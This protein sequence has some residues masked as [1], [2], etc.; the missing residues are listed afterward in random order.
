ME[1]VPGIYLVKLPVPSILNH[2][3][4]YLIRGKNGW[5][6]IDTGMNYPASTEIWE[7]TFKHMGL[8]FN[9]IEGIYLTHLHPDQYGASGW[10]QALTGAPVYLSRTE[11]INVDQILKKGRTTV[12][13]VGELLKENGMPPGLIS[14]VLESIEKMWK[15]IL[16]H[17]SI[18]ELQEKEK[19]D[20]GG[21]VFEVIPTPGHTDGHISFFCRREGML[22]SGDNLLPQEYFNV[23]LWPT[24]HPNPLELYMDTLDMIGKLPVK[25]ALPSHGPMLGN[26]AQRASELLQHHRQRL[27]RIEELAGNGANA[28]QICLSLFGNGL[29]VHQIRLALM[30]TLAHLACLESR[31]KVA[32]RQEGGIV[33]YR[34]VA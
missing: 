11:S 15:A 27:V 28:Y 8:G 5:S 10:L 7:K 19:L 13:V 9:D 34:R 32:S 2:V 30:E 17:P 26:C 3:N 12:P 4:C 22:F 21:R 24:S 29:T 6:I 25:L 18:S 23:G 33:M 16:P 1:V 20:L 31:A 14:E